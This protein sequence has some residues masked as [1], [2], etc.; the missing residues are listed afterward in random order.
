MRSVQI[1]M[2]YNRRS[3]DVQILCSV[4]VEYNFGIG[5]HYLELRFSVVSCCL[6]TPDCIVF[7]YLAVKDMTLGNSCVLDV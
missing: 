1:W 6:H 4:L 7:L 2:C 5:V 3:M